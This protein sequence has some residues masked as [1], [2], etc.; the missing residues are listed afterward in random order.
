MNRSL[1]RFC[2]KLLELTH[3]NLENYFKTGKVK[4]L[5]KA[6]LLSKGFNE[7]YDKEMNRGAFTEV[8]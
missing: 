7:V 4:Y 8:N 2:T 1:E 3:K 5:N 6:I